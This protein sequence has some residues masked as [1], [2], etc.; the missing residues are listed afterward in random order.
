MGYYWPTMVKDC[1]DYARRCQACQ[2]HANFMHQFPDVL[3]PTI[4]SSQF[5]AWGLDVVIPLPKS[6][7]T[8]TSLLQQ[9]ISQNGLMR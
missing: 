7:T 2:F 5:D 8:Y 1:L 3:H 4:A 6:M 9:I